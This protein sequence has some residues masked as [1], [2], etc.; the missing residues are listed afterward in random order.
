VKPSL[1][2]KNKNKNETK[3]TNKNPPTKTKQ[4]KTKITTTTNKNLRKKTPKKIDPLYSPLLQ[5]NF[6]QVDIDLG[7]PGKGESQLRNCLHQLGL[8]TCL[9]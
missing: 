9:Q 4:E 8:W 1:K 6:C 2:N 3:Q 5:I 7:I